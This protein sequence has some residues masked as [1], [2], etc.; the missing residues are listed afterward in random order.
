MST[1]QNETQQKLHSC[2]SPAHYQHFMTI[3]VSKSDA[4]RAVL[5]LDIASDEIVGDLRVLRE[6]KEHPQSR[7]WIGDYTAY[8]KNVN[9][10]GYLVNPTGMYIHLSDKNVD[11]A[12]IHTFYKSR[13][14]ESLTQLFSLV[15]NELPDAEVQAGTTSST[16]G[17]IRE[18]HYRNREVWF[19]SAFL[20][21]YIGEGD[22]QYSGD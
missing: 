17:I 9:N 5:L 4:Y 14:D 1:T 13:E 19:K 11:F 20:R 6:A 10:H 21:P 15:T 8:I 2:I 12:I 22:F 3:T 18:Q 7:H 16:D